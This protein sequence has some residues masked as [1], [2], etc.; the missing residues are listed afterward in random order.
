MEIRE[1]PERN[2]M[3]PIDRI[4]VSPTT[5]ILKPN[6]DVMVLGDEVFEMC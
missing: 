5:Y 3:L 4:L 2:E 1:Y 6:S